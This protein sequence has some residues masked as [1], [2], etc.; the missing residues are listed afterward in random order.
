MPEFRNHGGYCCGMGHVRGMFFARYMSVQQI[1][2]S[3]RATYENRFLTAANNNRVVEIT[4]NEGQVKNRK[5]MKA[6][7]RLG[8]KIVNKFRNSNSRN[9]V[10]V[11]HM[12]REAMPP[13]LNGYDES[14]LNDDPVYRR[15]YGNRMSALVFDSLEAAR[16]GA[17]PHLSSI[18]RVDSDTNQRETVWSAPA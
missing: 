6:L 9:V 14:C 4:L 13:T 16:N 1:M 11:F 7:Y 12:V 8:F 3:I 17:K 2:D 15:V 10:Y 5:L 18:V